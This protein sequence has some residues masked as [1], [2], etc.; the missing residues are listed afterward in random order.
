MAVWENRGRL[1][2]ESIRTGYEICAGGGGF[3]EWYILVLVRLRQEDCK[4]EAAPG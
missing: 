4:F 1:R 2:K 3:H